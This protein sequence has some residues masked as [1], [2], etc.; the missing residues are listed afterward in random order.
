MPLIDSKQ[1]PGYVEAVERQDFIRDAAFL[2]LNETICGIEVSP[3]T[4]RHLLWLQTIQSP[5]VGAGVMGFETLHLGVAAFFKTIAPFQK[6]SFM[7]GF[8]KMELISFIKK[9]GRLQP[10]TAIKGVREFVSETFLDSPGGGE[11]I[12]VS[13]YSSGAAAVNRICSKYGGQNPNPMIYPSAVDMPLKVVFQLLK[14]MKLD[15]NPKAILFN[16]LSDRAKSVWMNSQN[17]PEEN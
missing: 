10:G 15:D 16:G 6:P 11:K 5:F 3:M 7:G 2:G 14:C 13:F 12:G 9:V 8:D 1:I 4:F 17:K